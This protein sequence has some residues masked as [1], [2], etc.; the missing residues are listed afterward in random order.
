[1]D[2]LHSKMEYILHMEI[3]AGKK[4]HFGRFI[5][6]KKC[7]KIAMRRSHSVTA[8]SPPELPKVRSIRD[9]GVRKRKK[10]F[11]GMEFAKEAFMKKPIGLVL[12]VLLFSGIATAAGDRVILT[13]YGNYL[14]LAENNFTGQASQSKVFFEAKAAVAISGNIYLWASH[15]Y[16]PL[17]DSWTGWDSKN[18]FDAD[19]S[20][21][22]TLAKRV[23]AGGCGFFAGYFEEKQIAIRTEVGICSISNDIESIISKI[24][25]NIRLRSDSAKQSGIGVRGNL[26]F[27]YGL[28]KNI[29][30]EASIGYMYASDKI[31]DVRSNLGGFHL[32]LGL[33]IQL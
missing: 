6:I 29:F 13:L 7:V 18:S 2:A 5:Y 10:R 4:N 25:T 31:D 12:L 1:M 17:R 23:I 27:T 20:M 11:A 33:G 16:F 15:G 9:S 30:A 21:K 26:A 19:I 8:E 14:N 28:Y 3:A 32:A 22:R 24:D